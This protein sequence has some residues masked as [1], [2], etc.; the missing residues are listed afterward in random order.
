MSGFLMTVFEPMKICVQGLWHLGS[1]TVGCLT[2]LGH[3]ILGLD[4]DGKI[5]QSL[6]EGRSPIFEPGL[7][8]IIETGLSSGRLQFTT[9]PNDLHNDIELLWVTYDTPV[10][11]DDVADVDFV[12]T[13]IKIVLPL[14]TTNT[15]VLI[16]SQM[17]VGSIHQL[18]IF[19]EREYPEKALSFAYSPENLRLGKAMDAFLKPDRVVVGV[20]SAKDKKKINRMLQPITDKIEWMSVESAEMTK[21][22]INSFLAMSVVF[23]NEI[24]A[25]SEAVGA[26]AKEVERGLKSEQRIGLKAYLS[27]GGAFAGGTLARDIEF[28]KVVS[29]SHQVSIPLLESVKISND[30]HKAWVNRKLELLFPKLEGLVV[31]VWGLTYKS[32]TDT[33][34]RSLAVELCNWLMKK[35][36]KVRIHDPFVKEM[37][38]DWT[39]RVQRFEDALDALKG[40]DALVISTE[41]SEYKKISA[42]R[43]SKISPG[44]VVIDP[45]RFLL[46]FVNNSDLNYIAVGSSAIGRLT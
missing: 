32:D 25:L 13:Q 16:S 7:T 30:K 39:N 28:L 9:S 4:F 33:L 34:R 43:V 8:R 19:S 38:T 36:A 41:H 14:L 44:L 26:D 10:N 6:R 46:N 24:A 1:V 22:A 5:I 35:G 2:S 31:V 27:P 45:N 11:E 20:R 12:F 29:K 23:A 37:P 18:E 17:P 21:H 40:A 3:E 15:T 42:S